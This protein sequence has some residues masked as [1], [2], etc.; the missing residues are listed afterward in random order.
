VTALG[1]L[2]FQAD[3]YFY[4]RAVHGINLEHRLA[5][6]LSAVQSVLENAIPLKNVGV[7]WG[8]VLGLHLRSAVA[9]VSQRKHEIGVWV[10]LSLYSCN[11]GERKR[12][13]RQGVVHECCFVP[14]KNSFLY[15]LVNP[16]AYFFLR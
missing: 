2:G 3:R 10:L 7:I 4:N 8:A 1:F 16:F 11:L 6:V 14:N 15:D 5:G 13:V 9:T 12:L